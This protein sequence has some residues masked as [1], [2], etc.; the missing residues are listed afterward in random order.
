M[1][2]FVK[3]MNVVNDIVWHPVMC[4]FLMFAA[5]WFTF[6]LRGMQVR[7]FGDMLKCLTEKGDNKQDTGLSSFQAFATTVGGRVGTGNIAGT[8]TAIFMGGPGAIFWMW[9]TAIL[10]AST[11]M[12][13]CILGQA[14][15]TRNLGELTGGPAFYMSNGIK[16]KKLGKILAFL[17][18][19]AVF[20]GPGFLLPAMQ[21]Q[22]AATAV[23]VAFGLPFVVV[24]VIMT[25][26][27]AFVIMGGIKRIG[28]VA[29]FLAPVM[30]GIY[31]L[32]TI[33]IIVLNI[34]KVPG[35]FGSIFASAFGKDAVFG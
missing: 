25:A 6:H 17:F 27:V 7:R 33:I 11:G 15:K 19:I 13:E 18:C 8:A 21:T 9:V 24:G 1:E 30:C 10:G 16:N 4:V 23:N 5:L 20:I 28:Q 14:Y 34:G 32:I 26:I 12:V 29:E 2:L 35:M 22:T 31:F 3:V